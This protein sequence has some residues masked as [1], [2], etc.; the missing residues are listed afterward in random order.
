MPPRNQGRQKPVDHLLL[1][2]NPF[3]QLLSARCYQLR[4]LGSRLP[5]TLPKIHASL[6]PHDGYFTPEAVD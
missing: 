4:R 3:C 6:Q 2:D 1:A 5:G